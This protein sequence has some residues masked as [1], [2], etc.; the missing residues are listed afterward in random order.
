M[1]RLTKL[2]IVLLSLLVLSYVGLGYLL[3]QTRAERAYRPLT[4]FTEVLQHIQQD[5]VED[6]NMQLVTSSA[7]RGLL[8]ALD[9]NSSY[10]SPAEYAEYRK[11]SQNGPKGR[12]GAIL[13]KRF[14]YVVIVSVLPESPAE[15]AG[16]RYGDL[17]ESIEGFTTREMSIEQAEMLLA[18]EPGTNAKLSVVRRAGS[19][20]QTITVGRAVLASPRLVAEP[21]PTVEP[22]A[23]A[24]YAYLR[25]P[26]FDAGRTEAVRDALVALERRGARR[27]VLDLRDTAS[28]DPRE[29][30][31]TARLFLTNGMIGSL[32]GQ[33]VSTQEY[34]A[35]PGRVVWSHPVAVLIS[36]S[37]SG[38]AEILAAALAETAR[39]QTFGARSFGT[40][41]EQKLIPLEDGAAIVLTVAK[42][43]SP[44]GT[45]IP[46][47]GVTPS[48]E[49]T[50]AAEDGEAERMRLAVPDP[51][52]DPALR[53]AMEWLR[54]ESGEKQTACGRDAEAGKAEPSRRERAAR[55]A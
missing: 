51:A 26:S 54:G 24:N 49:V 22:G 2:V 36:N 9:S 11:R 20:S 1:N 25:I 8:E 53:R 42:Y 6:P 5:Y 7:L 34:A 23:E 46:D 50:A 17:V 43:Y 21:I 38:A 16:L 3:G 44:G 18:G 47:H 41:S 15:R 29:A 35:E 13:S 10:L 55:A 19:E 48:V 40:A 45:S 28:G 14:G 27:L 33:T 12:T 39:G 31:A 30:I 4:V 52:R 32:R 37:T